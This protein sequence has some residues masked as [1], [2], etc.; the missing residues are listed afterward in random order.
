MHTRVRRHGDYG[1]DAPI[2]VRN[3]FFA[4]V[5]AMITGAILHYLLAEKLPVIGG[6]S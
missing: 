6:S 2:V 3:L 5:A 4:G 1:I